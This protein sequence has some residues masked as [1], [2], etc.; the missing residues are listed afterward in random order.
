MKNYTDKTTL[1]ST[2]NSNYIFNNFTPPN[3]SDISKN[4]LDFC[5][6]SLNISKFSS[7]TAV[8]YELGRGLIEHKA[9]ALAIK[10]WLRLTQETKNVLL[11]ESFKE[12]KRANIEWIQGIQSL[13]HNNGFGYVFSNPETVNTKIFHTQFRQR[14]NDQNIQRIQAKI[15]KRR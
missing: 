5:K 6:K 12:A 10:Y 11:N 2:N 3:Y 4:H 13:L 9:F 8:Q 1:L 14:L 7:N 15:K